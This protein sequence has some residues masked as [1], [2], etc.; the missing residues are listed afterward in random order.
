MIKSPSSLVA[1]LMATMAISMITGCA[2]P[3]TQVQVTTLSMH[4]ALAAD[5]PRP[6]D[7]VTD[8]AHL[9]SLQTATAPASAPAAPFRTPEVHLAYVFDWIDDA[10]F[11]HFGQW[12][13]MP[14]GSFQW[15]MNEGTP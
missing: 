5:K 13:A 9:S 14:I 15:V 10:G 11:R 2:T 6:R 3:A 4:D 7:P 1:C 12:V 8:T